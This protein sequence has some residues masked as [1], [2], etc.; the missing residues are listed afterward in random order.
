MRAQSTQ[1]RGAEA[2]HAAEVLEVPER[3]AAE[4]REHHIFGPTRTYAWQ[5][6][7]RC[8]RGA[9]DIDAARLDVQERRRR[10]QPPVERAHR[11][12]RYGDRPDD[13]QSPLARYQRRIWAA[14]RA[15]TPRVIKLARA[16]WTRA[17]TC[18]TSFCSAPLVSQ[19]CSLA[20]IGA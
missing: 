19:P 15:S 13:E 20:S 18:S 7:E 1:Q 12:Q 11:Q 8:G 2:V 4:P 5:D 6:L 10:A 9:V 14:I 3:P 16:P 17:S